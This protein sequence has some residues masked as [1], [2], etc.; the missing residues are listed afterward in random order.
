MDLDDQEF[1]C[2]AIVRPGRVQWRARVRLEG[3]RRSEKALSASG[4]FEAEAGEDVNV[5]LRFER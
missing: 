4:V 1:S 3:Q 5:P 2:S